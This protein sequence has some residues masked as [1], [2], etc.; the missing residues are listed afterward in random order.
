MVVTVCATWFSSWK[1]HGCTVLNYEVDDEHCE[2]E[3]AVRELFGKIARDFADTT[4]DDYAKYQIEC[5]FDWGVFADCVDAEF[6]A[7]YGVR[8]LETPNA[9]ILHTDYNETLA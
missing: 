7:R 1:D 8:M 6:L 4:D 3:Q 2:S 9:M 5:G